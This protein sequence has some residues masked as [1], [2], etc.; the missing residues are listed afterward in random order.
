MT[1]SLLSSCPCVIYWTQTK[2]QKR[3][4]PRNEAIFIGYACMNNQRTTSPLD[5]MQSHPLCR[6]H[7]SQ[8]PGLISYAV[9]YC[10]FVQFMQFPV[11][12]FGWSTL[13][14]CPSSGFTCPPP[15]H[16]HIASFPGPAQLSIACSM[17]KWGK[18]QKAGQDLGMMLTCN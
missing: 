13:V 10:I 16:S 1:S 9:F 14:L 18:Q 7:L 2:E 12:D 8:L 4:R 17:E 5:V 3:G 6:M 15:T 11:L